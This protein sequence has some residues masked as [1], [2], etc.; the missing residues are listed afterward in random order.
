[1]FTIRSSMSVNETS[2]QRQPRSSRQSVD[3]QSALK[4]FEKFS[5]DV[6]VLDIGLPGITGYEVATRIRGMP[7]GNEVMLVALTR[8]SDAES[9]AR[10]SAAGF[11]AHLVK[12]FNFAK[13]LKFIASVDVCDRV[14]S[15]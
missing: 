1:M 2:L 4:R 9:Y 8:W 11:G 13:L 6:V 7:G 3:G 5:S 12:P 14:P 10:T 15:E